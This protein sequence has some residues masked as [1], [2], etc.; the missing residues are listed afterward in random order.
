MNFN[1]KEIFQKLLNE[2][3]EAVNTGSIDKILSPSLFGS[4][5]PTIFR[6]IE[7]PEFAIDFEYQSYNKECQVCKE[8][9]KRSLICLDCGK[10]VCDSRACLANFQGKAFP[11][12]MAH[13]RICGGGRSAF[14]QTEDCSVL[15]V[16][17]RAVFRKFVP[18]YVNE[19]GEGV[20]K[21][22]FGKE[23]KLSQEEVKKA[24]KMFTE[25]SYTNAQIIA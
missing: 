6:F 19:F 18:L 8:K 3:I 23:F 20:N 24:L 12:F 1:Y 5:L 4:C 25:Y 21:R 17:H 13:T 15:F 22:T 7:L 11:G 2:H 10:K 9:G 16:S 14:L